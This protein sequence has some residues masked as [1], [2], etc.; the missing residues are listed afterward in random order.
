MPLSVKGKTGKLQFIGFTNTERKNL[1]S[2]YKKL[3]GKIGK[4]K[5][6]L[7]QT[8]HIICEQPETTNLFLAACVRGIWI[9]KKSFIEDS[10]KAGCLLPER[11]YEWSIRDHHNYPAIEEGLLQAPQYWRLKKEKGL[12]LFPEKTTAVVYGSDSE[13]ENQFEKILKWGG[14]RC[15]KP[16]IFQQSPT[17]VD[18]LFYDEKH[19]YLK[20]QYESYCKIGRFPTKT[21]TERILQQPFQNS[22]WTENTN[23]PSE[24]KKRK[25]PDYLSPINALPVKRVATENPDTFDYTK[26]LVRPN[27]LRIPI[28]KDHD[29][30]CLDRLFLLYAVESESNDDLIMNEGFG[31]LTECLQRYPP[32]MMRMK[33]IYMLSFCTDRSINQYE[34]CSVETI[35]MEMWNNIMQKIENVSKKEEKCDVLILRFIVQLLWTDYKIFYDGL[36]GKKEKKDDRPIFFSLLWPGNFYQ[37]ASVSQKSIE[38]MDAFFGVYQQ[39]SDLSDDCINLIHSLLILSGDCCARQ[40]MTSYYKS[41]N[42]TILGDY[43]IEFAIKLAGKIDQIKD[44]KRKLAL[45][46]SL[47][48]DWLVACVSEYIL[49][50]FHHPNNLNSGLQKEVK[51]LSL[52]KI[53]KNYFELIPYGRQ[54]LSNDKRDI[55]SAVS[56]GTIIE[57]RNA[58][59]NIYKKIYYIIV[60]WITKGKFSY[61][62]LGE[63]RLHVACKRNDVGTIE[64]LIGEGAEV[65]VVDNCGWT[66]LHEACN[67]GH[68]DAVHTIIKCS[69]KYSKDLNF[70]A[71]GDGGIT[72]MHDAILNEHYEVAKVLVQYGESCELYLTAL[73]NLIDVQITQY[74]IQ[75]RFKDKERGD[76]T[77]FIQENVKHNNQRLSNSRNI[78]K[79]AFNNLPRLEKH[80]SSIIERQDKTEKCKLLLAKINLDLW[81]AMKT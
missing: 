25:D 16:E 59:G 21:I 20:R 31:L 78:M 42:T 10:A 4:S 47:A 3:D 62:Q 65:N 70:S 29:Q 43:A 24:T 38:L 37:T 77:V 5:T 33:K 46:E 6:L 79:D 80:I 13:K 23:N 2:K 69:Q 41:N 49:L 22:T 71:N 73:A 74:F 15:T 1:A 58:K 7:T 9:L 54:L 36:I 67:H 64:A 63:T 8:T 26:K 12:T 40:E 55:S 53:V 28:C 19:S 52:Q 51:S 66:P 34:S 44:S 76:D 68:I 45:L 11:E 48:L 57:K 61:Q 75:E 81:Q 14:V 32:K 27:L 18:Y 17:P 39:S 50:T 56:K 60:K 35:N 72:P 30:I